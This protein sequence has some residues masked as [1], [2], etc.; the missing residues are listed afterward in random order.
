MK[1]ENENFELE[2]IFKRFE[3]RHAIL[4]NEL[5]GEIRWPIKHLPEELQPNDKIH[6]KMLTA[7]S[8]T[9]EQTQALKQTLEELL[10]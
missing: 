9:N 1:H 8:K 2:F 4:E 10:N 3:E 5:T 7:R 6:L